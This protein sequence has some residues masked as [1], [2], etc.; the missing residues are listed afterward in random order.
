MRTTPIASV[1]EQPRAALRDHDGVEHDGRQAMARER[2]GD[3]RGDRARW[4]ACRSS[5]RRRRGPPRPRRSARRPCSAG[6]ATTPRD[7][8]RVLRGDRGDGADV[9]KTP[10]AANVFRSAWM[11]APPLESLPAIV[12]AVRISTRIPLVPAHAESPTLLDRIAAPVVAG[13][14]D[15]RR[16]RS[17]SAVALTAAAAQFTS[18][19]P[20]TAVPFTLTPHG[21]DAHRRR[22]RIAARLPVAR[23]LYLL[24]G[25]LGLAVFAPSVTL[26]ARRA[27]LVGPTG[28]YL[29]AYPVAA[30]VTAG[31]PSAA[32]I[33]AT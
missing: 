5:S 10:C 18:P 17:R 13:D 15:S 4:R 1:V 12:S 7:A 28:G 11:P 25:A 29:L 14:A 3:R 20:F 23:S 26:A 9:P 24:A 31:S 33:A 19:L 21:R 22:A 8:E 30:F 32:G 27:A 6:R 16:R 2:V